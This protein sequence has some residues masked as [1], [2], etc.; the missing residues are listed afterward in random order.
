M[1]VRRKIKLLYY[2][3]F[4]RKWKRCVNLIFNQEWA[5]CNNKK[6]P[7]SEYQG[8]TRAYKKTIGTYKKE[9]DVIL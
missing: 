4:C 9:E 2:K 7:L 6:C 3:Y 1:K 8:L 5:L